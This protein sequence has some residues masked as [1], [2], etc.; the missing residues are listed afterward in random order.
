VGQLAAG[1][2]HEVKDGALVLRPVKVVP[3][4]QEY[5]ST[6]EWRTKEA[7]A[8]AEIDAGR[9]VGPVSSIDEVMA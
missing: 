7:E 8:D 5:F 9:L 3:P 2:A 6:K 1:V 4:D